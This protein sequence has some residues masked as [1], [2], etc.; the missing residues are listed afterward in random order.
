M[1]VFFRHWS[2]HSSRSAGNSGIIA[3][4]SPSGTGGISITSTGDVAG[5]LA[6]IVAN[7]QGGGA[8]SIEANGDVTAA[9]TGIT[10][11]NF[12]AAGTALTII[13]N[14]DVTGTTNIGIY[15][16]NYGVDATTGISLS[17]TSEAVTGGVNGI[18]A[19]N[20]GTGALEIVAYGD[21][22][23]PM[24]IVPSNTG[25]FARNDAAST[26]PLSITT[27]GKVTGATRGIDARN[28]GTGAIEIVAHGDVVGTNI[29]GINA[30]NNNV[31]GTGPL[32]I[33]TYGKVTG[34]TFGIRALNYGTGALE[35]VAHGDVVGTAAN[36]T[37]ILARNYGNDLL[38]VTT[39]AGTTVTGGNYGI[40]VANFG[41]GAL[42]I[43]ANGDVE[44]TNSRG[45][46]ARQF[47]PAATAVS[48]MT[49]GVTG[50]Y[51]GIEARNYGTGALTIVA[52]G[53]VEGTTDTG[54]LA[55]SQT[56]AIDITVGAGATVAGDTGVRILD[57]AANTLNNFG[58]VRS[59]GPVGGVQI[60]ISGDTGDETVN[61][62]GVVTG[63][64]VLG[65]G[66]N[67]FNNMAGGRFNSGTTVYSVLALPTC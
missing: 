37:A 45:I 44:G 29:A 7:D 23:D 48:I 56:T 27:Y 33:T 15:A 41:T 55:Y 16:K 8:V 61:N 43:V 58:H 46:Y 20:Y 25:I 42:T 12:N 30:L 3:T 21:V 54:I 1:S 47:N 32:G 62:F 34:G 67:V 22:G 50:G 40:L 36:S 4:V 39:G 35:I 31:L 51:R 65:F 10:A 49:E 13:A 63:D 5:N 57:G 19:R 17:I 53:D 60:A 11:L 9:L 2:V 14:G 66:T 52:N 26:G 59:L 64:V 24:G 28:Y 18:V 6:G 38:Q